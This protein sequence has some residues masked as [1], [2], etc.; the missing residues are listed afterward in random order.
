MFEKRVALLRKMNISLMLEASACIRA[1]GGA[2]F[3]LE[4]HFEIARLEE[5]EARR[6]YAMDGLVASA[7][8]DPPRI[9]SSIT[10]ADGFTAVSRR[11]GESSSPPKQRL[12]SRSPPVQAMVRQ[13]L[14]HLMNSF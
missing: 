1:A 10:D 2:A 4:T 7:T 8:T 11:G 6:I 12:Q 5:K 13:G 3:L 14:I 9:Y